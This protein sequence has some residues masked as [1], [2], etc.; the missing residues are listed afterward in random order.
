M[1]ERKKSMRGVVHAAHN[2][3]VRPVDK[4]AES[5][6]MKSKYDASPL[7]RANAR[8]REAE[9]WFEAADVPEG[10]GGVDPFF[11]QAESLSDYVNAAYRLEMA[12]V[13]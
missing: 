13:V 2:K 1:V 11:D 6:P 7:T 3:P 8:A 5:F 9:T 10:V 12:E 4:S